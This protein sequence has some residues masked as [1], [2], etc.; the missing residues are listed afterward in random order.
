M[1]C[2]F[3]FP[4]PKKAQESDCDGDVDSVAS[5]DDVRGG[6]K[7]AKQVRPRPRCAVRAARRLG[8]SAQPERQMLQHT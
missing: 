5:E 3:G 7:L 2:P 6:P 4:G 1:T 8:A